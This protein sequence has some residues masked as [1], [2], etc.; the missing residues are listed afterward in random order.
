MTETAAPEKLAYSI[1]E[2]ARATGLSVDSIYKAIRNQELVTKKFGSK[3][4]I[5]REEAER[6][7]L[8]LSDD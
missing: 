3:P 5:L 6:W 7:L 8:S 4:L 1:P 2:L